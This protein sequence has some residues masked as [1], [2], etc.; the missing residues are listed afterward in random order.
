MNF[1]QFKTLIE[2]LEKVRDRSHTAYQLGIDL[3]NYDEL[4]HATITIL[5]ESV[6]QSEGQE[7]INWYL[8]EKI[9]FDGKVLQAWDENDIEICQN[10]ES[11]WETVKPYRKQ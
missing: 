3:M 4:F 6:F 7:W 10:V 5:I 11:L 8:Y 2:K 9:G 1:I